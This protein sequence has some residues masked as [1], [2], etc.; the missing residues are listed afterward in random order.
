MPSQ[1]TSSRTNQSPPFTSV[2]TAPDAK[3]LLRRHQKKFRGHLQAESTVLL[4]KRPTHSCEAGNVCPTSPSFSNAPVQG[5]QNLATAHIAHALPDRAIVSVDMTPPLPPGT[6]ISTYL[7]SPPGFAAH[8]LGERVDTPEE[9]DVLLV[10]STP[11]STFDFTL[12]FSPS[13]AA[14]FPIVAWACAGKSSTCI[15]ANISTSPSSDLR[16][17]RQSASDCSKLSQNMLKKRLPVFT[18]PQIL[19]NN[20]MPSRTHD[21]FLG[22]LKRISPRQHSSS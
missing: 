4:I 16:N 17:T 10:F 22:N 21:I 6:G 11:I 19:F 18:S 2:T 14:N 1:L 20:P 7:S 9:A 8:P 12:F 3:R 13:S 15:S 5:F